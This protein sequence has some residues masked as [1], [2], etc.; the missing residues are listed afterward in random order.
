MADDKD[1]EKSDAPSPPSEDRQV[2]DHIRAML[3]RLKSR[4]PARRNDE[5]SH[6]VDHC[7]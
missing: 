3:A 6:F 4:R 1:G 5:N 7:L 2:R